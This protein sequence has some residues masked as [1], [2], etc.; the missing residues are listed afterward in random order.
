MNPIDIC[1]IILLTNK[2]RN[3]HGLPLHAR[4][5]N[6]VEE[7]F[8]LVNHEWKK[9]MRNDMYIESLLESMP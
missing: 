4:D 3:E 6:R 5:A 1:G 9:I 2:S 7:V 8:A